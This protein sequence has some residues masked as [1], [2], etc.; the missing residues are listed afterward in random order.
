M[1]KVFEE[2]N[3]RSVLL[4]VVAAAFVGSLVA[5]P[6]LADDCTGDERVKVSCDVK[7]NKSELKIKIKNAVPDAALTVRF[8]DDEETDVVV[9]TNG[10]GKGKLKTKDSGLAEGDH[11][12]A[13]INGESTC[14]TGDV[15]C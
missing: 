10:K 8:D 12:Y 9:E 1:G 14:A 4:M 3:M 15:T 13:V 7:K 5:A 2:K 6:A 11:T